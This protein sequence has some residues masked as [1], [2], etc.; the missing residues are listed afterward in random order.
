MNTSLGKSINIFVRN[1]NNNENSTKKI[2]NDFLYE[3]KEKLNIRKSLNFTS[4]YGKGHKKAILKNYKGNINDSLSDNENS[5]SGASISLFPNKNFSG[6]RYNLNC[7]A[8]SNKGLKNILT[9][10]LTP[11]KNNKVDKLD[12]YYNTDKNNYFKYRRK[13]CKSSKFEA[14]KKKN[15]IY[16]SIVFKRNNI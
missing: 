1:E 10:K 6:K 4:S 9:N 3:N 15:K 13:E 7:K 5:S 11:I 2:K 8:N 12:R 16:K 14:S